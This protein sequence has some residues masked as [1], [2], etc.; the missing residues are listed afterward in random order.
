MAAVLCTLLVASGAAQIVLTSTVSAS[1]AAP[2]AF[3]Q[4]P[5]TGAGLDVPADWSVPSV[6]SGTNAACL[7]A[8]TATSSSVPVPACGGTADPVGSG[9]LRLT[10]AATGEEG[11]VANARALPTA[12]GLDITFD[13]YQ[14]HAGTG[15]AADG[16][17]FFLAATS[18]QDPQ[19]PASLGGPGGYL[20][21]S[22]NTAGGAGLADGYLGV[23]LDVFG[24]YSN[25][26]SDGTGCSDPSWA[27]NDQAV[28]NQV[29]VRG[30][31]SGTAGYCLLSSTAAAGGLRGSLDGG[32]SGT[33]AGSLVPVEVAINPT[34]APATTAS[35][36][37]V[38]AY[39]YVVAVTPLGSATQLVSG[40]LPYDSY[41]PSAD[42]SW[43][44]PTTGV[45]RQ[46]V[47]GFAASTGADDDI[48]EITN[49]QASPLGSTPP[50]LA[51]GIVD[52][53]A[54]VLVKGSSDDYTVYPSV[55]S[56][57]GAETAAP[58]ISTTFPSGVIPGTASGTNWSCSTAAPTVSC[59]YTGALPITS[60]ALSPVSVP[61]TVSTVA[62][63]AQQVTTTVWEDGAVEA[64]ASVTG[65]AQGEAQGAAAL[66]LD[67]V[68]NA[69]GQLEQGQSVT[70]TATGEVSSQGAADS[71]AIT[72][73]ADFPSVETVTGASGANWSCTVTSPDVNCNWTGGTVAAGSSLG[74]VT[75]QAQIAADASG[76]A[77]V[78]GVLS[79]AE[80][81]PAVVNITDQ[82][83]VASTPTLALSVSD[84]V[85]GDLSTSGSVHYTVN[86]AV[87]ASGWAEADDPVVTDN[88]PAAFSSIAKDA[89][90][91]QWSCTQVSGSSAVTETCAYTGTL[92]LAP[93]TA[94][95]SLQFDNTVS[96][97]ANTGFTVDD[98]A[99][100]QSADAPV[101][102]SSDYAR[103]G[104]GPAPNFSLSASAPSSA[105]ASYTLTV[106]ASVLA[107]GGAT[108]HSPAVQVI[109]PPASSF[110][111][112]SATGWNCTISGSGNTLLTCTAGSGTIPA[113]T[114]LNAIQATV[115][116]AAVGL[117]T[118]QVTVSDSL[119]GAFEVSTSTTTDVPAP[120]L[121]LSV[122]PM[123]TNVAAGGSYPLVLSASTA[124]ASGDGEAFSDLTMSMA[125]PT[126]ESFPSTPAGTGWSCTVPMVNQTQLTCTYTASAQ[127]PVAP[128]TDLPAVSGTVNVA[129]GASGALVASASLSD[130]GDGATTASQAPTVTVTASP[131]LALSTSGMPA[132]ASAGSSYPTTFSAGVTGAGGDAYNEPTLAVTLP[133]G[134]SFAAPAPGPSGWTCT[135]PGGGPT[136]PDLDCSSTADLP[137]TP[138]TVLGSVQA[139]IYVSA[140]ATLGQLTNDA[141]LS[142]TADGATTSFANST[143]TITSPPGLTLTLS[144]SPSPV[145]ANTSYG[146]TISSGLGS[147]GP[148]YHDPQL[149]VDLPSGETFASPAPT[150]SGW[151]CALS[152]G[153]S[154][155]NCTAT[156]SG[157]IGAGTA[158]GGVT[159][160][161]LI[162]SGTSGHLA[163]EASLSDAADAATTANASQTVV[164]TPSPVLVL[165]ASGP[166]A[167]ATQ[168][169]SYTLQL[170]ASLG[171]S[172]GVAYH[173]PGLV[174]DLPG[175]EAF[176]APLSAEAGW[177]CAL[178]NSDEDLTCTSTHTVTINPG[179][180]L[181]TVSATVDVEG[182][183]SGVLTTST[184]LSDPSD[185]ATPASQSPAV[186]IT[187]PPTMSLA[188]TGTPAGAAAGTHYSLAIT[189]SLAST[190]GPAYNDPELNVAL[191][192]GESFAPLT[193]TPSGW[194]CTLSNSDGTLGCT[195]TA[196]TPIAP[197]SSLGPFDMTVDIASSARGALT[198]QG[199][200]TDLG[201]D[202]TGASANATVV[203]TAVPVLGLTT[204]GTPAT[205]SAPSSYTLDLSPSVR[206]SGG[207]AWSSP[208]LEVDLPTGETFASPAPAPSGWSCSLLFANSE[209][210]C[211]STTSTPLPAGTALAV[212]PATVNIGSSASGTLVTVATLTDSADLA[213]PVTQE[214]AVGITPPAPPSGGPEPPPDPVTSTLP[215]GT[216]T[217]THPG[218]TT[219]TSTST[220]STSTTSTSTTSTST[221]STSTT[222]TSTTSTTV[223][224]TT[225]TTGGSA[226]TGPLQPP[227]LPPV[228]KIVASAPKSAP[229]GG[230]FTLSLSISLAMKGG[231][232]YHDPA[233][234][235]DLPANTAFATPAP[236]SAAWSCV[237]NA[238]YAV[239][240]CTWRGKLPQKQGTVLGTVE[241]RV[242]IA[243]DASG[244][245]TAEAS[246]SD[247]PDAARTAHASAT[248]KITPAP[249]TPGGPPAPTKKGGKPGGAA[250]GQT[251]GTAY[252][253][254]GA[255]GGVFSFG[256]A[257]SGSCDQKTRPCGPLLKVKAV[258]M[259]SAPT[260][261]RGYWLATANGDVFD[262]GGA[263]NYG[264]CISHAKTCGKS[265]AAVVGMVAAANGK[266][267]WLVTA[268]GAVFGFGSAHNYGSCATK[269]K[270]CGKRHGA[271]A[272]MARTTDGRGYWL[273][274]SNGTVIAFGDAKTQRAC[275]TSA[276]SCRGLL[277]TVAGIAT[278][279][280]REGY[281]LVN[282]KGRVFAY[283]TAKF[284][285]DVYTFNA[286]HDLRGKLVGIAAAA[287]GKSYWLV[288]SAGLVV[289]GRGAKFLGD[290]YT[291]K[292]VKK[293]FHPVKGIAAS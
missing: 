164:V 169:N 261:R 28:P 220:T 3:W 244:S 192:G 181:G 177:S 175:G 35:G 24:N 37:S 264:S 213:T 100:V 250:A 223:P 167:D 291:V 66:G 71:A 293:L 265:R 48:H 247:T 184:V 112:S 141:A 33:R 129:A 185:G 122:T 227:V 8:L 218:G 197:G 148:A 257:Y 22:G 242:N 255:D 258:A 170:T 82:A 183:A 108:A 6:P 135:L 137:I 270:V 65:T 63:G 274:E 152:S 91:T 290:I 86:A 27:G 249:G 182:G 23:G 153:N 110:S 196:F 94:L 132:G 107:S 190:S 229:A 53:E 36:L 209:L 238:T 251:G 157:T 195:S 97:S 263:P 273:A 32:S 17:M 289:A 145:S 140:S 278:A 271:I 120:V 234:A 212:V 41:L 96:S 59:S 7:S 150:P 75:V 243:S 198:T 2:I 228:L 47:M 248:V 144:T 217:T 176:V 52:S 282:T 245:A 38:P 10:G 117:H 237:V 18:P 111:G 119:D 208:G 95:Q 92:P 83:V 241:A 127:S 133:A 210:Q 235:V 207:S 285:G 85:G 166:P 151:T 188:L 259:A 268:N 4:E 42:S 142:D 14:Y 147:A 158:L 201:D 40:T 206:S 161:V 199:S 50:E 131:V 292:V 160:T 146:L 25:S 232:A 124:A 11:G 219:T 281:W 193:T 272:G 39:S 214:P 288:S 230:S 19:A 74:A 16:L 121:A 72:F 254:F 252:R 68:D 26:Q 29:T 128:G 156:E 73:S 77:G 113:G 239:M 203:V 70:Y 221:T 172:G 280:G 136:Y 116:P 266:G 233:F 89:A 9:A 101:V 46:V 1:P 103:V 194:A 286:E 67:F 159:T 246:L 200:L 180:G 284:L 253:L 51:A 168:G 240:A 106:N 84:N 126:G 62:T 162:A 99:S 125:L 154:V 90:S 215:P 109:L 130:V 178:S 20:A 236:K 15:S 222:S 54:G 143:V 80:A 202:A 191:P 163:T 279:A 88:F 138:G 189:A 179:T 149:A 105:A 275:A 173:D 12:G 93:G 102:V 287:S 21:Y 224:S 256:A 98:P 139:T 134:E 78:T 104:E 260:T 226:G 79:S 34:S 69:G 165:A 276:R 13:T 186:D 267:Y 171:G 115:V 49:V 231:P 87:S 31:G 44:N 123:S 269:P 81:S 57:G 155:L 5:F 76:A 56:S 277:G 205:A 118:A 64:Q 45:P 30:P 114:N 58:S 55:S 216:T 61:A 204:S 262:F 174:A 283:G 60:G 187:A 225:T 211:S 43:L